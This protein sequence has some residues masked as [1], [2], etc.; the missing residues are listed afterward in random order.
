MS[1]SISI[2]VFVVDDHQVVRMGL[3]TMLESAPDINVV[4]VA[5]SAQEAIERISEVTVDVSLDDGHSCCL[6]SVN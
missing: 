1:Q 2:R 3:K 4:G 5:A 6:A